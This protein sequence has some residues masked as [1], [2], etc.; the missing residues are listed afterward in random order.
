[1][2]QVRKSKVGIRA[3][4]LLLVLL[5]GLLLTIIYVVMTQYENLPPSSSTLLKNLEVEDDAEP[6]EGINNIG[7]LSAPSVRCSTSKGDFEI[8][9]FP[10]KSPNGCR[11]FLKMVQAGF[12]DQ[13]I[14]FFRVNKV[15]IQFG[16]DQLN[17]SDDPF[18]PVRKPWTADPNPYYAGSD[19]ESAKVRL[20]HPWTRGT[21]A[22]IGGTQMV[23]TRVSG[24]HPM[25]TLP[26]DSPLGRIVGDGMET[27]FD[28]LHDGYGNAIDTKGHGPDQRRIFEQGMDYIRKEF[29]KTDYIS[30]CEVL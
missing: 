19:P 2:V 14:A 4:R 26:H 11:Q 18:Q 27:V 10:E 3:S 15:A 7:A 25:G 23:I 1:M 28:R 9:L 30:H 22:M 24:G 29:P 16:A 21:I 20:L 5:F 6:R 13:S 8:E 17:R 12:F